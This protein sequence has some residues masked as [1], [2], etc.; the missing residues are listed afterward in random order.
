[1]ADVL[2]KMGRNEL[3]KQYRDKFQQL[4]SPTKDQK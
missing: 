1:M 4:T 2:E 3:A